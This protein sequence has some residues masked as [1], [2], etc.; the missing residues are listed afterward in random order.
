[1]RNKLDVH[2]NTAGRAQNSRTVE[3]LVKDKYKL[4]DHV[5]HAANKLRD[6]K[7]GNKKVMLR[8]MQVK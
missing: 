6:N 3:G 1:M 2:A 8:T 7:D 4:D 5:L